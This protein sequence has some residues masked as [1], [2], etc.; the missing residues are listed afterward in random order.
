MTLPM[1]SS[2]AQLTAASS[3][4]RLSEAGNKFCAVLNQFTP[5]INHDFAMVKSEENEFASTNTR[6]ET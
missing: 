1:A 6:S 5:Q 2:R 4:A 3:A